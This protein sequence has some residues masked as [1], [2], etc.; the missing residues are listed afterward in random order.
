MRRSGNAYPQANK[1]HLFSAKSHLRRLPVCVHVRADCCMQ[2]V[3]RH[4]WQDIEAI[5]CRHVETNQEMFDA[6]VS[7]I[8][9]RLWPM[10]YASVL[11]G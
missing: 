8:K 10:L 3:N 4:Q 11:A 2:C 1:E 5:D 7:H 6:I 9:V